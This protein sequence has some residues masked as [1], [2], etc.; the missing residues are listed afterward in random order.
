MERIRVAFYDT[1]PYDKVW[2]DRL[3]EDGASISP[4]MSIILNKNTAGTAKG[5]DVAVAFVNDTIE[6]GLSSIR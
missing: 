2:F 4:I 5:Y 3:K 1:K 6:C